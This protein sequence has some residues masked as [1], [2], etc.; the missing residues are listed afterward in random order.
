MKIKI[1]QKI[2]PFLWFDDQAEPA[3]KF[4]VSLFKNSKIKEVARYGKSGAAG[5][6]RKE[7][8]V[9]TVSFQLAGQDFTA[10]NGGPHFQ[11]TEAI[12]LVINCANQKEVDFYWE[13]L[14]SGGGRPSQ[15][16]WLKD[17]YGLSWQV[18]PTEVIELLTDKDP[19][20]SERAM[21]AVM[22]MS[23]LDLQTIR[24]AHAGK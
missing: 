10:I 15:C 23:K 14:I 1:P 6:G 21:A 12:S 19:A 9:M 7:G 8:T 5:T 17:K 3:A 22:G 13:K 20:K 18:V 24:R 2:T 11:F 16:G 4:Y